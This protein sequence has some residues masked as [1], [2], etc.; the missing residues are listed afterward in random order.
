MVKAADTVY[1]EN[2]A[3]GAHAVG[4]AR[5]W[6]EEY[7]LLSHDFEQL[8]AERTKAAGRPD[9]VHQPLRTAINQPPL[10]KL[11]PLDGL[12]VAAK[13]DAPAGVKWVRLRYRHLTQVEDYQTAEMVIDAQTGL[14]TASI[15]AAFVNPKWKLMYFVEVVDQKG[16]GRM[17]PDLDVET[18]CVIQ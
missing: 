16:N 12:K 8:L 15:P 17:Y 5:H 13:V 14:Y 4:F 3:F 6:K 1:S 10:V 18:P 2:L 9:A 11:S 7:Q